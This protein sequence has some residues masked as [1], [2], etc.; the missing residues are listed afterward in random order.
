MSNRAFQAIFY[1]SLVVLLLVAYRVYVVFD[2]HRDD[3][4]SVE[5]SEVVRLELENLTNYP[6]NLSNDIRRSIIL[7][8]SIEPELLDSVAEVIESEYITLDSLVQDN[9][10]QAEGVDEL[11]ALIRQH[12]EI[13]ENIADVFV[14][15][16]DFSDTI[17][18]LIKQ[19]AQVLDEIIERAAQI[20]HKE[21][22]LLIERLENRSD[23]SRT[24]PLT[25]LVLTVVS[26]TIIGFLY[27]RSGRLVEKNR[28]V[29]L[30]L[31][32][33][34]SDLRSEI[35]RRQF[36][37]NLLRNI[38]NSS[39]S[40]IIALEAIRDEQGRVKDF[41]T[42]MVNTMA[43][44]MMRQDSERMMNTNFLTLFPENEDLGVFQRYKEV[45]ESGKPAHFTQ[46][47]DHRHYNHWYDIRVVKN[48]DGIVITFTD[49][50]QSKIHEQEMLAK[51]KEL[52][53][54]NYQLEQFAYI[55]SHDLQEPLRKV[56]A[57]GDRLST[58]FSDQLGEQ[59]LDYITR[60]QSASERMQ[61]LIDDLLKYSRVSRAERDFTAV[62]LNAVYREVVLDLETEI[63]RKQA[64]VVSDTL[65]VI[66]ADEGQMRQLF[67]NILSN[68]LKYSKNEIAPKIAVR[69]SEMRILQA[70][71][72][73][74]FWELQF[75]DNGIGF[76][77]QY[78]EQIFVIFKRL[79][80][81][82]EFSG[83]GI[84]LA[85]CEKI[86]LGH[87]GRIEAEST[88]GVGT[89]FKVL[90]PKE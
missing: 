75:V 74:S 30:L 9:F 31:K 58:K 52:E 11:Y 41:K 37:Q 20:T 71:V 34:I 78:R 40:G 82:S 68:A 3:V 76:D 39:S 88:P 32:E 46:F 81:R 43:L 90:L 23:S 77:P 18:A 85:I 54:T 24:T 15:G 4:Q 10:F 66:Q 61:V 59:G 45:A 89:T 6:M 22:L 8:D 51:Q 27:V 2:Q 21:Q 38:L 67:Q 19:E 28:A 55:A 33:K 16:R 56:R 7:Q 70:E 79:H 12:Y 47:L 84:G 69:V 5:H 36:L 29:N 83:T 80:G 64:Q 86:V 14:P 53:D 35:Q 72:E 17:V 57:F 63:E 73:K 13:C 65:P 62:D 50:T 1:T 48:E 87:G 26:L 60:M 25:L 42:I 44:E 49:V